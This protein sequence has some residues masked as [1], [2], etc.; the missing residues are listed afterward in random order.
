MVDVSQNFCVK[1]LYT[2]IPQ[3]IYVMANTPHD[4]DLINMVHLQIK[5]TMYQKKIVNCRAR[6]LRSQ[7]YQIN[8]DGGGTGH[9]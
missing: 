5:R 4:I 7:I 8:E 3:H 1:E 6:I 9:K 2:S